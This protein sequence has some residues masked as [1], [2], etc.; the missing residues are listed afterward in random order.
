MK[1][2]GRFKG[3]SVDYQT[4]DTIFSFA[5]TTKPNIIEAQMEKINDKPLEIKALPKSKHRSLDA[6]KLL[7]ASLGELAKARNEDNWSL[8]LE[9]LRKYGE[10]TYICVKP[11]AVESVKKQWRETQEVGKVNINGEEAVQLLCFF[12]SS[13]YDTVQFKR[14]LDGLFN[15]MAQ[16]GL[17]IPDDME[18]QK[19]LDR[20]E[21]YI[22]KHSITK[23]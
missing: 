18:R 7:W 1:V 21:E 2:D 9:M 14:L 6:N 20:W 5:T 15:E 16:E 13:T 22:N 17:P 4:G 23:S 10:F 11:N 12:G 19:A 3:I 8:Y